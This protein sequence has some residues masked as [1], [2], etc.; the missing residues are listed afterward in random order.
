MPGSGTPGAYSTSDFRTCRGAG[1]EPASEPGHRASDP[2]AS[3]AM[4]DVITCCA[5][6]VACAMCVSS[7]LA[8]QW[9]GPSR[10][11][12]WSPDGSCLLFEPDGWMLGVACYRPATGRSEMLLAMDWGLSHETPAFAWTEDGRTAVVAHHVAEEPSTI[13]VHCIPI[14]DVTQRRSFAVTVPDGRAESANLSLVV[15]GDTAFLGASDLLCLDLRHG[16]VTS[17]A[18]AIQDMDFAA[19]PGGN[20]VAYAACPGRR[21]GAS[22]LPP[23]SMGRVDAATMATTE[24]MRF[25][26]RDH[27]GRA[28][29][30][31]P[32]FAPDGAGFAV[33]VYGM[34]T[35]A[36]DVQVWRGDVL[37]TTLPVLTAATADG[38]SGHALGNIAWSADGNTLWVG[39]E[40]YDDASHWSLWQLPLGGTPARE[41]PLAVGSR[42]R[43]IG[44]CAPPALALSPEARHAAVA[45]GSL[46]TRI[47]EVA[48]GKVSKVS[49]PEPR[50][51]VVHVLPSL[52]LLLQAW[53]TDLEHFRDVLRLVPRTGENAMAL[54]ALLR[55]SCDVV[56]TEH[57]VRADEHAAAAAA[58]VEMATSLIGCRLLWLPL[59]PAAATPVAWPLMA[60]TRR[61]A[62]PL[63]EGLVVWLRRFGNR[64]ALWKAGFVP[65]R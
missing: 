41:I 55:G 1:R 48:T 63:I 52:A 25:Q 24:L 54:L 43:C 12:A 2:V 28:I 6:A 16:A 19:L 46:D 29:A 59:H 38:I 31:W 4:R 58:G 11:L 62:P 5:V 40:R 21:S 8:G 47:V 35:E 15:R 61:Q 60:V 65:M 56:I 22:G 23:W 9:E 44:A 34:D 26:G 30:P 49:P 13:R 20:G 57:A 36:C 10:A 3:R 45:A 18:S 53:Q 17:R 50:P 32:A 7:P 33:A 42:T 64:H 37:V 39:S 51:I 14:A 27:D